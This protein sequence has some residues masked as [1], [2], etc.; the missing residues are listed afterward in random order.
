MPFTDP[1]KRRESRKR[2]YHRKRDHILSQE[3]GY[4][5]RNPAAYRQTQYKRRYGLTI[6]Q[7][8]EMIAA[9]GGKCAIC[10]DE[11]KPARK[12]LAIHV[13]HCHDTMKV[14]GI[15]CARCNVGI[16]LLGDDP[17]RMRQAIQYLEK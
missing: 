16:G 14:R 11:F 4:R 17:D 10:C 3:K 2:L 1:Q 12:K 9:Q 15:L 6:E 5:A 8:N 13:D 7:V